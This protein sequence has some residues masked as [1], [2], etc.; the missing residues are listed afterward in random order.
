MP[1]PES[2]QQIAIAALPSIPTK[3]SNSE[4]FVEMTDMNTV[5]AEEIAML[6]N[7]KKSS[8]SNCC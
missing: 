7:R 2:V 3:I 5:L 6:P 4:S 8:K 1:V